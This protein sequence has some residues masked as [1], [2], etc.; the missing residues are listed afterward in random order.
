MQF[1][2][3]SKETLSEYLVNLDVQTCSCREWQTTVD[4]V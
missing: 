2:V 1:E 4:F 3:K